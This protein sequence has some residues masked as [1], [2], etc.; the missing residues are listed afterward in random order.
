MKST[1]V[2]SMC[3]MICQYKRGISERSLRLQH[4]TMKTKELFK[5]VRDKVVEKYKSGWSYK[6]KTSQSLGLAGVLKT[7]LQQ[8]VVALYPLLRP[9]LQQAAVCRPH[10]EAGGRCM[11]D[12]YCL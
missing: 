12:V 1:C 7:S 11:I 2:Q 10:I 5:Q 6:K 8:D 4:H 9:W 3:H